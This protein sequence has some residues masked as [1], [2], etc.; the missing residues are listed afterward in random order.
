MIISFSQLKAKNTYA[1]QKISTVTL[2]EI[3]NK[4]WQVTSII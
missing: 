1:E 2:C 3:E 4:I